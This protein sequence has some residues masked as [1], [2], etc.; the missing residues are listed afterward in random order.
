[1]CSKSFFSISQET[2]HLFLDSRKFRMFER[3]GYCY[4]GVTK[5]EFEGCLLSISMSSIIM[6]EFQHCQGFRP[7]FRM[8]GTIYREVS[9]DL[10]VD[11]F[12]G[13]VSLWVICHR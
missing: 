8:G 12:C 13:S 11:S 2:F 9:F 3:G 7:C 6:G 10:L 4:R 5:H 1:M